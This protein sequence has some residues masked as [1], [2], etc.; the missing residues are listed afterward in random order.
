VYPPTAD[1]GA[2]GIRA[3]GTAADLSSVRTLPR[4]LRRAP[5]AESTPISVVPGAAPEITRSYWIDAVACF[6]VAR[7]A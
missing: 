1:R 7:P 6:G 4:V 5:I 2:V 3:N